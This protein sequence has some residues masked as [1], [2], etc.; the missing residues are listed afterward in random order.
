MATHEELIAYLVDQTAINQLT[1]RYNR[2]FDEGRAEDYAAT[3]TEDGALAVVG[4]DVV[5]GRAELARMVREAEVTLCHVT[6]NAII[7]VDGDTATQEVQLL[8]YALDDARTSITLMSSGRYSD[9]LVRTEDGWRF[10]RR[11]ATIHIM[12]DQPVE[13]DPAVSGA[14]PS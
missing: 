1:A 2:A 8:F 13:A 11:T 4:G 7:E 6:T 10:K 12:P 5:E 9:T 3:F 14:S